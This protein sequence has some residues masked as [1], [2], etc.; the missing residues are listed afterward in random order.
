MHE[1][2]RSIVS[3]INLTLN[4]TS[5]KK[6][7]PE[8]SYQFVWWPLKNVSCLFISN[9][10][11]ISCP[12]CVCNVQNDFSARKCEYMFAFLRLCVEWHYGQVR[13]GL[14]HEIT[15]NIRETMSKGIEGIC[16]VNISYSFNM[17]V[18]RIIMYGYGV[19]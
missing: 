6:I 15:I 1:K 10:V 9:G 4:W 19:I 13:Y 14:R 8:F 5:K 16:I 3:S 12:I 17:L 7:G 2:V 18:F 11:D